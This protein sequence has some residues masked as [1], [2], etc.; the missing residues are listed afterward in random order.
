MGKVWIDRRAVWLVLLWLGY[1]ASGQTYKEAYLDSGQVNSVFN[2]RSDIGGPGVY[3]LEWLETGGVA[4]MYDMGFM[5]GGKVVDEQGGRLAIFSDGFG[6]FLGDYDPVTT[7]PWGWLPLPGYDNPANSSVA[8]S[9]D[10]ATWPPGWSAWPGKNGVGMLEADLETFWVMSDSANAEFAYYPLAGDSSVRGL[11]LEVSCRGYQWNAM[12]WD[13]FLIFT[14]DI[15]NVGDKPLDSLVTGFYSDPIVGGPNDYADDISGHTPG[16]DVIYTWDADGIGDGGII[17]G[18][19][20]LVL[21]D[22]PDNIGISS[23]V[24]VLYGGNN[25]PRND[26]LMWEFMTPGNYDLLSDPAD[27][28]LIFGAGYFSLEVGDTRTVAIA[29]VLGKDDLMQNIQSARDAYQT[30]VALDDDAPPALPQ[31]YR[32]LQNFPNPFN[33]TTVISYQV[34]VVSDVKLTVYNL[35]GQRVSTLVDARQGPGEY[36]VRWDGRD[37]YGQPLASG[38]YFYRL[39]AGDFVQTRKMILLR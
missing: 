31:Q 4:Y 12:D 6:V 8:L 27:N 5:V 32:L 29:C 16:S 9:D 17:P 35:L 19:L 37:L 7:D 24:S 28:V 15:T 26:S 10:P 36:R 14:Y 11:G 23:V 30:I 18:T 34:S 2:N 22:T 38:V 3:G 39:T 25:R 21:L 13:D 20:A 1:A 33:P